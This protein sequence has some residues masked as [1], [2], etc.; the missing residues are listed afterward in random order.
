M[1][2]ETTRAVRRLTATSI[3]LLLAAGLASATAFATPTTARIGLGSGPASGPYVRLERVCARAE[4]GSSSCLALRSVPVAKTTAGAEPDLAVANGGRGP[5]GGFTPRQIASMYQIDNTAATTQTIAI[6]DAYNDPYARWELNVFDRHYG[7]PPE[8]SRSLRKVNQR[9]HTTWFPPDHSGWAG[10]I[11]LDLQA[12]RGVC[13]KCRILLVEADSNS[14]ADLAAAVNTGVRLGAGVI[15]NSYGG[16]EGHSGRAV[17]A[18]Y[19]HRGVVITASTGDD[20]WYGWDRANG[21]NYSEDRPNAPAAYP[22]VVAVGGTTLSMRPDGTRSETVW[23]GNGRDDSY[24]L[25]QGPRGASGGGCSFRFLAPAWQSAVAGYGS[26]GC[27]G[28]RMV[29]DVAAVANPNT[30]YAVYGHYF[31]GWARVGGTSLSSPIIAAMYGLVGGGH[32]VAY[33]A[34]TLYD[35]ATY[36]PGLSYDVI[37]GGNAFCGGD[38]AASCTRSVQADFNGRRNPNNLGA[39]LVDCSYAYDGTAN[40]RTRNKQC[41]ATRGFDGPSGVGTPAGLKMFR[42]ISPYLAITVPGSARVGSAVAAHAAASDPLTGEHITSYT[43]QW[44]DGGAPVSGAA[45][46]TAMHTWRHAG[47]YRVTVAVRDSL[48]QY[49]STASTIRIS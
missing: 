9:G 14:N 8:T 4:S 46:T 12:V 41:N 43:W 35:N 24:G 44:G 28:R 25:S 31:G 2:A 37:A 48:G 3:A 13:T 6:V 45:L 7:L 29:G 49:A 15:S 30:G 22:G 10:E 40:L 18:A 39:G 38:A 17:Q 21:P 36:R 26:L 42:R 20:G 34:K 19:N 47:S 33:P 32:A 23:N 1:R 5:A 16:P 11:A 27:F